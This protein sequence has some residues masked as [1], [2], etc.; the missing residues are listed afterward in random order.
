MQTN[1]GKSTILVVIQCKYDTNKL[2]CLWCNENFLI[3]VNHNWSK[4]SKQTDTNKGLTML[5]MIASAASVP[6]S[7]SD[8]IVLLL[9][10]NML[11]YP[12]IT[13]HLIFIHGYST[14]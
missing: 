1:S 4:F 14:F 5:P 12:I 8:C 7:T 11:V 3:A 13:V 2:P 6:F 9:V 10:T